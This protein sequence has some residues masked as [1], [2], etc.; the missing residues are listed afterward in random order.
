M[1]I[2]LLVMLKQKDLS[3]ANNRGML[4]NNF[5]T[6]AKEPKRGKVEKEM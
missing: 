5:Q 3:R 4:S 6:T 2:R 1:F